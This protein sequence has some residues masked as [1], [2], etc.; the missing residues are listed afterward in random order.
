MT[1]DEIIEITKRVEKIDGEDVYIV[2]KNMK[3]A[4]KKLNKIIEL[5]KNSYMLSMLGKDIEFIYTHSD[6]AI[7][8]RPVGCETTTTW[9]PCLI[10]RYKGEWKRVVL[11]YAN[12]LKCGWTGYTANPTDPDLY[13][14]LKNRFDILRNL[15]KL[16]FCKCPK[17]GNE[18]SSKAIWVEKDESQK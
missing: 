5:K 7:A 2:D 16:P 14:T 13:I 11:Q 9:I 15:N 10:Y 12:C 4:I 18:I 8:F 6:F 3:E 1:I 17:C